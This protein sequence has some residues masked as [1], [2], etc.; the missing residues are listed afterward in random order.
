[1][2]DKIIC[3][4]ALLLFTASGCKNASYQAAE[5]NQGTVTYTVSYPDSAMYGVKSAFFPKEIV[6][7]FKEDRA[8]FIASAGL[9]MIQ[10]VN[11]LDH[12]NKTAVSLLLDQLRENVGCRL[13][14]EEIGTNENSVSYRFKKK[15]EMKTIAGFE[16]R[17]ATV[18]DASAKDL[19]DI[20]YCEKIKFPYWNSPFKGMDH[21]FLEYTHTINNLTMKLVATKVDLITP[22]DTSLLEVRGNYK[23]MNQKDFF[24]YLSVL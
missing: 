19:F 1:M 20:Y 11:L 6:L 15:N 8:T 18:A 2:R 23:W 12:K 21:L 17:K 13:T 7:V 9:G 24:T 3:L 22:I 4:F 10:M 16:C 14:E 5:A